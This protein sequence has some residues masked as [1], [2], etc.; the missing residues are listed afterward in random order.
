MNL[1]GD[2]TFAY[3][4]NL[5]VIRRHTVYSGCAESVRFRL[6]LVVQQIFVLVCNLN[7]SYV[8]VAIVRLLGRVSNLSQ[9]YSWYRKT[10]KIA[11]HG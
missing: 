1:K 7:I 4:P 3:L 2:N 9:S 10:L 5:N 8:L 6:R 11:S